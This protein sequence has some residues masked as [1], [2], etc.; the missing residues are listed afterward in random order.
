MQTPWTAW[1]SQFI[2]HC[3]PPYFV[4]GTEYLQWHNTDV[5]S[6]PFVF[7]QLNCICCWTTQC[8]AVLIL[9]DISD[10]CRKNCI[11]CVVNLSRAFHHELIRYISQIFHCS[12]FQ[13]ARDW[14][15]SSVG[16]ISYRNALIIPA[17]RCFH[18]VLIDQCTWSNWKCDS[19]DHI[20]FS[21]VSAIQFLCS[22]ANLKCF[23]LLLTGSNSV[24]TGLSLPYL[25]HLI[26][27]IVW[28]TVCLEIL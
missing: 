20:T 14:S 10:L 27:C 24:R 21:Q 25:P 5:L 2:Q 6:I 12:F 8:T 23:I 22:W 15:Y 7:F 16:E 4:K 18:Q 13:T 17:S 9:V 3:R 11:L 19:L 1:L 26:R 28:Q